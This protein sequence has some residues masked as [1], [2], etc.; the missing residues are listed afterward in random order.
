MSDIE[1]KK[2]TAVIALTS[3]TFAVI[4]VIIFLILLV[5]EEINVFEVPF[6]EDSKMRMSIFAI[7]LS[8]IITVIIYFTGYYQTISKSL[9][10]ENKK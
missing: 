5:A 10:E 4:A 1:T 3:V 7:V 2:T 9:Y 6:I 8:L